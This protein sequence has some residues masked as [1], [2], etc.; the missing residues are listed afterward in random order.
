MTQLQ[1]RPEMQLRT[2]AGCGL[3]IGRWPRFRYNASGGGGVAVPD[4]PDAPGSPGPDQH[5]WQP[6]RFDPADL[7]IP[8]L[9][10]RTTRFLGLPLPP[11]LSITIT[12]QRLE[13]RW[14]PACGA[15][16][17]GFEACFRFAIAGLYTAPDLRVVTRLSTASAQGRRHHASGAPLD[18]VGRGVLVGIARVEPCGEPW[19]DRFLGLPDEALAILRC[20]ISAPTEGEG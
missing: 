20:R 16:D 5:G 2:E 6:L 7:R 17:L 4:R 9:N 15:V 13:G 19:L 8:P 1:L 11:G 18:G 14:Q 10:T 12:P 3:A